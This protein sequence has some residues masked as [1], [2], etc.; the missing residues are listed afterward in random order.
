MLKLYRYNKP[1]QGTVRAV[2]N[3]ALWVLEREA[4]RSVLIMSHKPNPSLKTLRSVE[5]LSKLSWSHLHSLSEA[6]TEVSFGAGHTIVEKV[7]ID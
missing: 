2:T 5:I 3:G 1:A 6:L 4:Y 7:S